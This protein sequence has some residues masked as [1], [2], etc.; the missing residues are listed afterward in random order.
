MATVMTSGHLN[1]IADAL[2][3]V[4]RLVKDD[5]ERITRKKMIIWRNKEDE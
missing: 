4:L 2:E 3:E 5:Q 1:R